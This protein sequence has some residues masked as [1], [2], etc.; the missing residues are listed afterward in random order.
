MKKF[1][2]KES[3]DLTQIGTYPQ[4]IKTNHLVD[5]SSHLHINNFYLSKIEMPIAI[6]EPII[7]EKAKLTDMVSCVYLGYRLVISHKLKSILEKHNSSDI[8]Y[9]PVALYYKKEKLDY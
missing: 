9:L 5:E 6:P 8:Q 1:Q 4:S 7:Q 3:V 2:I